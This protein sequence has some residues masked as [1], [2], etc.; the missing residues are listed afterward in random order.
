MVQERH[1]VGWNAIDGRGGGAERTAWETLLEMDRY[2][3]SCVGVA[4][5]FEMELLTSSH[6]ASRCFV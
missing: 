2:D 4:T 3:C 5:H 6:C 1:R